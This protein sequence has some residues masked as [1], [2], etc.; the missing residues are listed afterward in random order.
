MIIPGPDDG[1]VSLESTKVEGM[2]EHVVVHRTHPFIMK[3]RESIEL[4][5]RFLRSGWFRGPVGKT[6]DS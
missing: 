6:K 3:A 2:K 5:I 1:K 4:T